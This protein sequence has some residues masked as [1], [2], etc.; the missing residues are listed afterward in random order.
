MGTGAVGL[1]GVEEA[2]AESGKVQLQQAWLGLCHERKPGLFLGRRSGLLDPPLLAP[3]L[4]VFR[5]DLSGVDRGLLRVSVVTEVFGHAEAQHRWG[6]P[7]SGQLL[8]N[9]EQWV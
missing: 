1:E 7:R 3:R 8:R 2:Q 6:P 4:H 5:H 9:A